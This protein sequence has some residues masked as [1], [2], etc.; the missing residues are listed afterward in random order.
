MSEIHAASKP[1][2][3]FMFNM[4]VLHFLLPA[5]LFNTEILWLIVGLPVAGSLAMMSWIVIESRRQQQAS[6]L[7]AAHW[8]LV[9]RRCRYLVLAYAVSLTV[10]M[11]A[12]LFTMANP[13]ES[14]R[15]IQRSVVGWL[16]LLPLSL[17]LVVLLI[18]ETS[19]L[20]QARKQVMPENMRI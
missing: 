2:E 17:T 10:F 18:L 3:R 11:L 20:A 4:A 9:V 6:K 5:V 8:R 14:M 1:H 19:A 15:F 16:S 12:Y 13:D 7:V